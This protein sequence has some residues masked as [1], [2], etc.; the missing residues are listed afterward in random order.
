MSFSI[1]F[2]ILCCLF[3]FFVKKRKNNKDIV[4]QK[5]EAKN[6]IL[7]TSTSKEELIKI[8]AIKYNTDFKN[9]CFL[10]NGDIIIDNITQIEKWGRYG[11]DYKIYY[12]ISECMYAEN[13]GWEKPQYW[14]DKIISSWND[15]WSSAYKQYQS[16]V[17]LP[18]SKYVNRVTKII[19]GPW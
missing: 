7:V 2:L 18:D 1:G 5:Y 16:R 13:C 17:N 12:P 3:I 15:S 9:V 19:R 4:Y 6:I 11:Y 10:Y 8:L 14:E